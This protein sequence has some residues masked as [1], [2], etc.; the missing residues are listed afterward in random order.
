[1]RISFTMTARDSFLE[2]LVRMMA[3]SQEAAQT[4]RDRVESVLTTLAEGTGS[5]QEVPRERS[6]DYLGKAYRFYYRIRG[7]TLWVLAV[8]DGGS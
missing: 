7:E 8:W 6:L 3:Q 5:E 1:M 2:V 4:F